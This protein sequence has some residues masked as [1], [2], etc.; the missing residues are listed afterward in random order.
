MVKGVMYAE[1]GE[2]SAGWRL[3]DEP[4]RQDLAERT[5]RLGES[6]LDLAKLV[7][8]TAVTKNMITQLVDSGTSVHANYCEA[9]EAESKKEFRYRIAICKKEARELA[10]WVRFLVRA[11]PD[12]AQPSEAVAREAR[13]L[14]LV[15]AAIHRNST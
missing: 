11:Q 14:T 15:F 10:G 2:R 7:K 5:A 6:V 8:V 12:L 4:T 9:D 13:E 1:R 3:K